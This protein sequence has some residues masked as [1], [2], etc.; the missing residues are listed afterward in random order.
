M[1][2]ELNEQL[3]ARISKLCEEGDSLANDGSHQQA[4]TKYAQAWD[5]LPEPKAQWDAA[6]WILGAQADALFFARKYENAISVLS[7]ALEIPGGIGNPFLHL[8]LG[9]SYYEVSDP[10]KAADELTRAYLGGGREL[11][12]NEDPKYF[13]MLSQILKPPVGKS[14]L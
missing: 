9:E 10:S 8:R 2:S 3:H 5:L 14:V 1:G 11:F 6:L 7:Q 4:L 13:K 12:E